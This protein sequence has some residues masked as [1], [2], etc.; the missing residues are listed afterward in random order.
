MVGVDRVCTTVLLD[1]RTQLVQQADTAPFVAGRVDEHAASFGRD[2]AQALAQLD[3]AVAP[4]GTKR[5]SRQALRVQADEHVVTGDVSEDHGDVHVSRRLFQRMNV[6]HAVRGWQRDSDGGEGHVAHC[7]PVAGG[8]QTTPV[9][10]TARGLWFAAPRRVEIRDATVPPLDDGQVLVRTTFSGIS[11]GTEM[12]AFRGQLDAEMP[13]DETIGALGGTFRY[14]FQYGYSCVGRVEQS[15]SALVVGDLVFAFHPH[16]DRFVLDAAGAV[17]LDG[18]NERMSTLLPMAETA[19]QITLD[20][21]P[22]F[23]ETVV[24]FGLGVVGL[25]TVALLRRAGAEV[26]AV[27]PQ[28]WRRDVAAALSV[29]AVDPADVHD[30][31]HAAGRRDGVALVIEASGNPAVLPDA[32]SL[33]AHEGTALV[34]SWYGTREVSL[35]LGGAFHRRRLTIRSTQVSTIPAAL[36]ARWDRSRRQREVVALLDSLPLD[37]LATHTF[38][39]DD[40]EQA[41]AAIDDGQAG[42]V[43]VAL[44]YD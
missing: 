19:L 9:P 10:G 37:L 40:A 44:G 15:R 29:T 39:F 4:E 38:A 17:P 20:A 26:I 18:R 1:V 21:G 22:V 25:L 12:L 13:V 35:P 23:R 43:H 41:Y 8:G 24:V 3:A 42:L 34:A 33:L 11:A 7:L 2:D 36:S 6:E 5:I 31:M 14:P 27:E 16:Q 30:A 32:L 28:G